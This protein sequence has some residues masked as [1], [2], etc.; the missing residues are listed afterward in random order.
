MRDIYRLS[1]LPLLFERLR[2]DPEVAQS[3]SLS[4]LNWLAAEADQGWEQPIRL[5]AQSSFDRAY[6]TQSE[7]LSQTLWGLDFANPV[8]L[9]AGFDKDG[10]AASAWSQLGLG[11]AEL[12]TV[13]L[14]PQ[15][16]N[17]QPRLFRLPQDRAALNRMGFN[18]QG[19]A[20]L[21]QRLSQ[22]ASSEYPI[23]LGVNLGKS[24]VTPLDQAAQDYLGSFKLLA[25][26]GSYFV[27]NVSSPNT[28]GLRSLQAKSQLAPILDALQSANTQQKP[29]LVKISPDLAWENIDDVIDLAREYQLAGIIA[30]NTTLS[31]EGLHTQTIQATGQSP[32]QEAGGISGAPVRQRSTE[33]IRYIYQQTDGT[34]PIVGVGGI[35]TAD[36]A[37]EKIVAGASLVQV[38]TG[39]VYEGPWIVR[40][41]LQG[42][43][44]KL[45][46]QRLAH[47]SD[48]I[49]LGHGG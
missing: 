11:F 42:L 25:D 45:D 2:V 21:A 34:L 48:A 14:K 8:G 38:Y 10:R 12:G 4:I 17:P 31:R 27:V 40:Q 49:G 9:A 1:L 26:L 3:R 36:D 47:I 5:F 23:P 33:V 22:L 19:A 7:R 18:N 28:P 16:G 44:A 6:Q 39:F 29:L 32:A 30:T 13:T 15:P 24:K 41:I 20:Q 43:L 35:F 46:A 37:W